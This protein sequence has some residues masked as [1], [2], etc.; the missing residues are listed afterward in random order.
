MCSSTQYAPHSQ[1]V[2][3]SISQSKGTTAYAQTTHTT[4]LS[5]WASVGVPKERTFKFSCLM[6]HVFPFCSASTNPG[7]RCS[8]GGAHLP[9]CAFSFP[10]QAKGWAPSSLTPSTAAPNRPGTWL[11]CCCPRPCLP[12]RSVYAWHRPFTPWL[13]LS[14]DLHSKGHLHPQ[15]ICNARN[16]VIL[17]PS[18]WLV[19]KGHRQRK[20]FQIN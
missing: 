9:H 18:E 3:L 14:W 5:L 15:G 19:T 17:G 2:G 4:L 11:A 16:F 13:W 6:R 10:P 1:S 20:G 8:R 12:T 7:W